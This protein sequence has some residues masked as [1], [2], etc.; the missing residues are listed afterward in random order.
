MTFQAQTDPRIVRMAGSFGRTGR[1]QTG[2]TLK[3]GDKRGADVHPLEEV[4]P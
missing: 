2:A 4:S 3:Y 1:T